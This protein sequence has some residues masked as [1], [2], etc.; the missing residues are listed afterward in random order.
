M[1]MWIETLNLNVVA[2]VQVTN[3]LPGGDESMIDEVDF[4][5]IKKR[6]YENGSIWV[7]SKY[8]IGGE[9]AHK[10]FFIKKMEKDFRVGFDDFLE[11]YEDATDLYFSSLRESFDDLLSAIIFSITSL[12]ISMS[13]LLTDKE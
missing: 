6:I 11:K 7:N 4:F 9:I 3:V 8:M 1:N 10:E 5:R 12:S 13:D 2:G